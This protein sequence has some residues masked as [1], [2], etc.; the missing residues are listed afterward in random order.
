MKIWKITLGVLLAG[1][2]TAPLFAQ[3]ANDVFG[4]WK[5]IDDET[6]KAKSVILVYKYQGKLYGRILITMDDNEK[7]RETYLNPS[8]RATEM[9]D[10]ILS[11]I[12]N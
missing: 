5:T 8:D 11:G 6:G 1:L 7:V 2:L 4:L 10:R 9:P 3:N 12:L